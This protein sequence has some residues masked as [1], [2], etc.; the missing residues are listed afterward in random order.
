MTQ[1]NFSDIDHNALPFKERLDFQ[2]ELIKLMLGK[3]HASLPRE[4]QIRTEIEW[5]EKY[6]R[7]VSMIIDDPKNVEVRNLILMH[8]HIAAAEYLAPQLLQQESVQQDAA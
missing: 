4:E 5:A 6:A 1:E 8:D 7:T 3:E 2:V